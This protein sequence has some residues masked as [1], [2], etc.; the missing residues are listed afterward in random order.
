M[1]FL[2]RGHPYD[3]HSAERHSDYP[4]CGYRCLHGWRVDSAAVPPGAELAACI[5]E[6]QETDGAGIDS[7][8]QDILMFIWLSQKVSWGSLIRSWIYFHWSHFQ[9]LFDCQ[10]NISFDQSVVKGN[11]RKDAGLSHRTFSLGS[12]LETHT[13]LSE[14]TGNFWGAHIFS[15]QKDVM[16][17]SENLLYSYFTS[18]FL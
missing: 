11:V 2:T 13:G 12:I 5:W 10:R 3:R 8:H 17:L 18:L 7:K 1:C 15:P 16:V 14:S 4:S 6:E 9:E